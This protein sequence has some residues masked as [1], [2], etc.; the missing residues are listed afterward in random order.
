MLIK[1][2]ECGQSVSDTVDT[3]IH[4]GYA[5]AKN[6]TNTTPVN[7][8]ID[9]KALHREYRWLIVLSLFIPFW[10]YVAAIIYSS[11]GDRI[12]KWLGKEF[13]GFAS[14]NIL[15]CAMIAIIVMFLNI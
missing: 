11:K 7:D 12:S 9:E 2:P 14:V 6:K 8:Y 10:G 15:C 5:I 3:C 1:C 4:C 13:F